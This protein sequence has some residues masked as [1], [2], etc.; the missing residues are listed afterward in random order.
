MTTTIISS[1]R[2]AILFFTSRIAFLEAYISSLFILFN[3]LLVIL[4]SFS[5]V[6]F[7]ITSTPYHNLIIY[8]LINYFNILCIIKYYFT[9]MITLQRL[10]YIFITLYIKKRQNKNLNLNQLRFISNGGDSEI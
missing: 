3:S 5:F 9:S 1:L 8:N 7:F 4:L 2:S 10:L 6:F